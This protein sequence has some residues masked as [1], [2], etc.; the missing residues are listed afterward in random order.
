MPIEDEFSKLAPEY[1]RYRPMYPEGLYNFLATLT[2]E[3]KL[4]WDCGTGNGQAAHGL[5]RYYDRVL[6]T[7]A[8]REQIDNA[9]PHERITFERS[10]SITVNLAPDSVDIVTV[11]Q[12]VHWFNFAEFYNEVKRV[13]K[14]D[15]ILAVWCYQIPSISPEIDQIQEVYFSEVLGDYWNS[16]IQY[17]TDGYQ[18]IPFPFEEIPAPLFNMDLDWTISDMIGFLNTW[19]AVRGYL[20]SRGIHPMKVIEGDLRKAWG[21]SATNRNVHWSIIMRAGKNID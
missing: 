5:A 15:G 20:V 2:P 3:H 9:I 18:T 7:D 13:L 4:A 19:S 8:S 17:V 16:G 6:A 12:A 14:P 1:A 11:A 21:D 10:D